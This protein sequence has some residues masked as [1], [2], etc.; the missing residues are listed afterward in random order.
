M[1]SIIG[2]AVMI[3][4]SGFIAGEQV[5]SGGKVCCF[6]NP[7][8]SGVCEITPTKE[9]TCESILKYLNT[10]GTVGKTY[11]TN[12]KIRGG[13]KLVTCEDEQEQQKKVKGN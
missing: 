9:E 11:C 5:Q 8:Y 6:T 3:L 13:W 1:K 7:Q 12:T 10:A 2:L 4:F